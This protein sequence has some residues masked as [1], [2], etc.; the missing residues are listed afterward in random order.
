MKRNKVNRRFHKK[1]QFNNFIVLRRQ[2]TSVLGILRRDTNL[3]LKLTEVR[4]FL[5]SKRER[6]FQF[7]WKLTSIFYGAQS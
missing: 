4:H 5:L 2:I 6:N 3:Y 1:L 7:L